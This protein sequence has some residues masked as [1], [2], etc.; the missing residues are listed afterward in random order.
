MASSTSAGSNI[1][2]KPDWDALLLEALNVSSSAD[3]GAGDLKLPW[4]LPAFEDI[5][6]AKD[7]WQTE[8]LL[9]LQDPAWALSEPA[10]ES[11]VDRAVKRQR[12]LQIV[13]EQAVCFKVVRKVEGLSWQEHR[14]NLLE[15]ALTRWIYLISR[16]DEACPELPICQSIMSCASVEKQKQ[17]LQDWLHSKAPGTLLKRVNSLLLFH[18]SMGWQIEIPYKEAVIYNYM[19]DSRAGG[20]KPSQLQSLREALIFVRHVFSMDHLEALVKSR[21]CAGVTKGQRKQK[22]KAPPL[23][24]HELRKLHRLLE[25]EDGHIW[26]RMFAGACLACAY[27]RARWGDFQQTVRFNVDSDPE[28]NPIYLEFQADVFKTMNAKFW[29]D[30]P[31]V[32]V[33]PALGVADQPWLHSWLGVRRELGLDSIEPPMPSPLEDGSPCRAGVSTSEVSAWLRLVLPREAEPLSAHSLKRTLLSYANKRGMEN[34][35]K[36]ILGHHCHQGKMA[37]V[38]GDDHA[39]RPLR[40]LESLLADIRLGTFDPDATRAGRFVSNVEP[41]ANPTSGASNAVV[42]VDDGGGVDSVDGGESAP[43]SFE[44]VSEREYED[45]LPLDSFVQ[46]TSEL[47]KQASGSASVAVEGSSSS[48]DSETESSSD[49]DVLTDTDHKEAS[50]VIGIPSPAEGTRFLVHRNTKMLHMIADGNSRV[51]L[52]G[53][54]VQDVHQAAKEVR[55]DSSV[56]SMC[57]RAASNL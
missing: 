37:D 1:G 48:S 30:E 11:L 4:E 34:T 21:R 20:A 3:R 9:G 16:W 42:V 8:D 47:Q 49:S 27:M 54:L 13:P 28:G 46:E 22:R 50:R 6:D 2:R 40:L 19:S 31:A 53:R 57:K 44:R 39:A 23:K 17:I 25:N 29:D 26:D 24:V 56:C 41:V 55:F 12:V 52:C 51:M 43:C 10:S 32:W 36:L 7:K 18:R 33:A 38:Y 35:D 14:D 5:F 15:K 45:D